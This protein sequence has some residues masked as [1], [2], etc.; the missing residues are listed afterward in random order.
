MLSSG[1]ASPHRLPWSR[2]QAATCLKAAGGA[3]PF[4]FVVPP[5]KIGLPAFGMAFAALIM[6]CCAPPAA[7]GVDDPE[8]TALV[9]SLDAALNAHDASSVVDMFAPGATVQQDRGLQSPEQIRG[10]VDELIRQQ[11]NLELLDQPSLTHVDL[12]RS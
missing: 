7:P 1:R 6:T 2:R 5:L 3:R 12:P 11:I 10:W 9:R 4:L 8:A